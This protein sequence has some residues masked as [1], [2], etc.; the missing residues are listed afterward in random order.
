MVMPIVSKCS[1]LKTFSIRHQSQ[2]ELQVVGRRTAEH[3][4]S[5][6]SNVGTRMWSRRPKIQVTH[7]SN[8]SSKVIPLSR[9]ITFLATLQIDSVC[10]FNNFYPHKI[11]I[12]R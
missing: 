1:L 8:G 11:P 10:P 6:N 5:P 7:I 3:S 4:A 12:P 9:Q 2:L